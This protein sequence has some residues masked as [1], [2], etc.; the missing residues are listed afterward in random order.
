MKQYKIT[1]VGHF[2]Q[3]LNF[4]DGQT[5]KT[6]NLYNELQKKYTNT[7]LID[8]YNWR[9]RIFN[10]FISCIKSLKNSDN[11]II[12]PAQNGVKVFVPLFAVFNVIYKRK[13]HYVVVGG[14]LPELLLKKP[15]LIKYLKEYHSI[16]VETRGM[17]KKLN[18]LGLMN[19]DI[20]LNFK[21]INIM[22]K[23]FYKSDYNQK[24]SLCMFSRV[25]KEKGIGDA[26]KAVSLI[27]EKIQKDIFWLDIYGPIGDEYKDE[28]DLIMKNSKDFIKY[29]GVVDSNKSVDVI[30]NYDFLLF[31][32]YYSGEG[33]AGTIIDAFSSGVPVIASDW[34]YNREVI[35]NEKNGLIFK[36]RDIEELETILYKIYQ[37]SYDIEAMKKN[38]L[39]EAKKY[40]PDQA[41]KK[42]IKYIN[43]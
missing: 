24:C 43:E 39:K 8:T 28:F 23:T 20:L 4:N 32:T 40:I 31:P 10:L 5:I 30:S 13:I 33:L 2:A 37:K 25:I 26:I 29:K 22:Q 9:K 17:K 6:R 7:N 3:N 34:K 38:C 19:V 35:S 36:T 15:W 41:I 42:L 16:M 11:V 12:L 21:N 1:I 27:N 18:N 14:W